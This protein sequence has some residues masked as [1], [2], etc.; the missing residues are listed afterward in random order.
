MIITS[1]KC[2]LPYLLATDKVNAATEHFLREGALPTHRQLWWVQMRCPWGGLLVS[3][4]SG[5]LF[6]FEMHSNMMQNTSQLQPVPWGCNHSKCNNK[7][8]YVCLQ[9]WAVKSEIAAEVLVCRTLLRSVLCNWKPCFAVWNMIP[10]ITDILWH[11]GNPTVSSLCHSCAT[12]PM[13]LFRM[14]GLFWITGL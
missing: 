2:S 1:Y 12:R 7:N 14:H 13:T 8:K 3:L 11:C 10:T 6:T 4:V 5:L 9:P